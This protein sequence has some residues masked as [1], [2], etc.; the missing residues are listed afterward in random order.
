[1]GP[2]AFFS[3]LALNLQEEDTVKLRLNFSQAR[4]KARCTPAGFKS[5]LKL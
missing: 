4:K 2:N 1:M 5:G 3:P